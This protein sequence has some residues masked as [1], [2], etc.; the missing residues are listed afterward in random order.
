MFKPK[1]PTP[2]TY[3]TINTAVP[4]APDHNPAPAPQPAPLARTSAAVELVKSNPVLVLG[5]LVVGGLLLTSMFLAIAITAGSL[6]LLAVVI[7][8]LMNDRR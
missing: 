7:R 3:P 8:S 5:G 6:A 4:P 2:D 1:Y